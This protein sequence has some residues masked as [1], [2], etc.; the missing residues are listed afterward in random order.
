MVYPSDTI[1][2]VNSKIATLNVSRIG[3]KKAKNEKN[4]LKVTQKVGNYITN[5][6]VINRERVTF[7]IKDY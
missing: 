7:N 2:V 6:T 1:S 5:Y 3:L 4:T